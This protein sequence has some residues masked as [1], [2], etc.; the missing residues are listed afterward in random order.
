MKTD[1]S[2]EAALKAVEGFKNS[3]EKVV[4]TNGCFDIIHPGHVAYLEEARS[5]GDRL[6]VALNSD[7]SVKRLNYKDPGRP[8][9][10]ENARLSVIRGLR[11]V[12]CAFL[13]HEDTPIEVIEAIS[14]DVLVKGGDWKPEDIVG[15]EHVLSNDGQVL[16][17]SFLEGYS[18]TSI[19]KKIQSLPKN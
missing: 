3:G 16:S 14:P 18:T 8:I 19:V 4:F 2:L 17:L 9:Q 6:V 1:Q 10:N 5:K 12:D 7:D 15:S 13:F 11:S